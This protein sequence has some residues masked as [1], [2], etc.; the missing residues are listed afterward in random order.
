MRSLSGPTAPPHIIPSVRREGRGALEKHAKCPSVAFV[1]AG[2]QTLHCVL[3]C[4][5]GSQYIPSFSFAKRNSK[6]VLQNI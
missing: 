6:E 2:L 4:F 1:R 3:Q 5:P